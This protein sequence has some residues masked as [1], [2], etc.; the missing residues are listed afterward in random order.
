MK[1]RSLTPE[2]FRKQVRSHIHRAD[3]ASALK[4]TKVWLKTYPGMFD[5]EELYAS[6]LGDYAE[7]VPPV[8]RK[9]FKA[10]SIR[11]LRALTLRLRHQNVSARHHVRNEFYWQTKKYRAQ[12]KLGVSVVKTGDKRGYYSQGVGA[13]WHAR[14][15]YSSGQVRKARQWAWLS[16][17]AWKKYIEY[18]PKYYNAY[19]HYALAIGILGPP[20]AAEAFL[21]KAAQLSGKA[22]S[23]PEFEEIRKILRL[24]Y[25]A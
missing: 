7:F 8:R 5:A 22:K 20:Q 24:I 11:R 13:A 2:Y 25:G 16:V 17:S 23:F 21:A 15:L 1:S 3:Y 9:K 18:R 12:Y 4:I 19:V 14:T 10:E 6:V